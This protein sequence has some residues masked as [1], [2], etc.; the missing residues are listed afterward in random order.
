MGLFP[1]P[2]QAIVMSVMPQNLLAAAPLLPSDHT[3][4]LASL[5]TWFSAP[6]PCSRRTSHPAITHRTAAPARP[7]APPCIFRAQ[8]SG[9]PSARLCTEAAQASPRAA[10]SPQLPPPHPAPV[11]V[12]QAAPSGGTTGRTLSCPPS[13]RAPPPAPPPAAATPRS[14]PP[15]SPP[16]AGRRGSSR[17]RR[18]RS[19]RRRSSPTSTCWR[20]PRGSARTPPS[21]ARPR[22]GARGSQSTTH[23]RIWE[24][25]RGCE[26]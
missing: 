20:C 21:G 15:S 25:S 13:P 5:I 11:F 8:Q 23:S 7:T 3:F 1:F 9:A 19:C 22:L 14:S 12:P 10:L 4:R 6:S 16:P 24:I 2:P 17:G 18:T 26:P